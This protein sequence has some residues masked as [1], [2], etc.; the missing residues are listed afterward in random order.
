MATATHIATI[1][2]PSGYFQALSHPDQQNLTAFNTEFCSFLFLRARQGLTS[3][4]DHFNAT[5][6]QFFSGLGEWLLKQVDDMYVLATSLENLTER[7][8]V[9]AR[10]AGKNGCTFFIS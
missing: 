10:E 3:S 4:G 2:F 5:T 7:L 1:D 8:E 9:V 6:D